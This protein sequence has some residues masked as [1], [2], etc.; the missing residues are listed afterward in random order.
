M[1]WITMGLQA[2]WSGDVRNSRYIEWAGYELY[3]VAAPIGKQHLTHVQLDPGIGAYRYE[4]VFPDGLSTGECDDLCGSAIGP[5]GDSDL[6]CEWLVTSTLAGMLHA[7]GVSLTNDVINLACGKPAWVGEVH[8]KPATLPTTLYTVVRGRGWPAT[9][10]W[11]RN[12]QTTVERAADETWADHAVWVPVD[13]PKPSAE[14]LILRYGADNRC[15]RLALGA[16]AAAYAGRRLELGVSADERADWLS[17]REAERT[18][19]MSHGQWRR[20][21]ATHQEVRIGRP[22]VR[23]GRMAKNRRL[24]HRD[25]LR[26]ALRLGCA[27]DGEDVCKGGTCPQRCWKAHN[28]RHRDRDCP[29]S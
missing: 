8:I 11:L 5:N 9:A 23:D 14:P 25:D 7:D 22:I 18:A 3:R 26:R 19:G 10:E 15:L 28:C 1:E 27:R 6:Q 17:D 16:E 4:Y 21:I 24:I 12:T 20:W 29:G 2:A 13:A